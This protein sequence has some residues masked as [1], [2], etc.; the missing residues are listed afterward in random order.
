MLC[1]FCGFFVCASRRRH[2][3]CALVTGVQTC[4]L[5]IY[6]ASERLC[7][8]RIADEKAAVRDTLKSFAEIGGALLGAQDDGMALDGI[9]ATGPGWERFRTLVATASALTNVIAAD[10]LRRVLDGYHRFLLYAP[11]LTALLEVQA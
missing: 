10:P 7:N 6:R 3:R 9:I 5:P 4:A 11:R 2:T 1:Y 8:T